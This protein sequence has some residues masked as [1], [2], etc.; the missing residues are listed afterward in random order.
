MRKM[1]VLVVSLV[2][3]LIG[4]MATVAM[5]DPNLVLQADPHRH[6]INGREVGPRY[7]DNA[8]LRDAFTQFHANVHTHNGVTGEIGDPAPGL[9]EGPGPTIVS[10]P[11]N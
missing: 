9:H 3:V 11:C 7:C 1:L 5:A 10:G 6:Y 8:D 2:V 4:S